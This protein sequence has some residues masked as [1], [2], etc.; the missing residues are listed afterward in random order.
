M[1]RWLRRLL[2]SSLTRGVV[3]VRC[4]CG[5][6]FWVTLECHTAYR[7]AGC[8]RLWDVETTVIGED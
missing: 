8:E 3:H 2:G 1:I 6:D 4:H 5:T 7:C